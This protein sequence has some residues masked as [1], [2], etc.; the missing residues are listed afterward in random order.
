MSTSDAT[1]RG[2]LLTD[3][4]SG[5]RFDPY[6]VQEEALLAWFTGKHGVLVCA[7]TGMGKTVI[8][9]AAMFEALKSGGRA[10]YTTPLVALT[11]QKFVEM[12]QRAVEWGFS[13]SD[14]GLVTGNRRI[15]PQARI[16]VVVAEILL[17]RLLDHEHFQFDD[18][19]SVVMDE[20]H[21]FAD[22]ERGI[23]WEMSLGLLPK[24]IRTLL[25][26]AT[27]GNAEEFR[28]WL[29]RSHN[30]KLQL[31]QSSTRRVPLTFQWVGD[32]ML[33][34]LVVDMAMGD[35]MS[36]FTPALVFC[37]NREECWSIAENLKGK[38]LIDEGRQSLLAYELKKHDW[39]EGVGPK[40]KQI[41]QRG[42]GV[43]HAGVLGKYRRIVEHLF[44]EK[45]LS[46]TVCTETLAAGI[47]L[48]ARSVILPTILKGPFDNKKLIDPS[49]AHQMFGRAGRPQFDTRGY[50]YALAHD[51]DVKI[52]RWAERYEQFPDNPK[53]A[54]L[55]R[56]KKELKK[57][58][59]KRR[60][61]ITYWTEDQFNKLIASPP[62]SLYSKGRLP[63]R[64]LAHTLSAS[65]DV[66]LLR[67]LISKRFMDTGR[68][69]AAQKQLDHMLLTLWRAGFVKLDPKPPANVDAPPTAEQKPAEKKP[70]PS[71]LAQALREAGAA[72]EA[73][74]SRKKSP[75]EAKPTYLATHAFA[76]DRLPL[77]TAFRSINPLF[78][79]FLIN[80]L[81]AA[82]EAEI[83]QAIE[84]VLDLPRPVARLLQVPPVDE[85]PPGPLGHRID[86]QLLKLGL[87]DEAQLTGNVDENDDSRF[88]DEPPRRLTLADKLKLLF[89]H[90]Y[91]NVADLRIQPVWAAG[92]LF[93]FGGDFNKF[94]LSRRLQKQEGIVF[95]HLLRLVLLLGEFGEICPAELDV[96]QWSTMIGSIRQRIVESCQRV[97]PKSTQ[98]T[99]ELA[100]QK[101]DK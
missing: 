10:Y 55:R 74:K 8:A 73:D 86:P 2:E 78:G 100:E 81:G 33:D 79:V 19:T 17:N 30:R 44:Q 12:Q 27:V 59:P 50:V 31:V 99:L 67:E 61:N 18:V 94:V 65:P 60:T 28:Y 26:S 64:V 36:R 92:E 53:D 69:A 34:E 5:L 22:P 66:Q 35:E 70:P 98:R 89:D 62:G 6:P 1:D 93:V 84:S 96:D 57:K 29:E 24:H 46:V 39:S 101:G 43:H 21:S 87:A 45:L 91:P 16:L 56:R 52:A 75:F 82:N 68:I 11:D 83:I 20:F 13:E 38:K 7:P 32:K 97:D 88:H 15:N 42:V 40:L 9:E 58:K 49:G 25:L 54:T 80:H 14:V 85:L 37:F 23:V 72:G 90:E 71:L 51:D 95:R 3:Y 48:P 4:L 63:W 47:N 76:T 77:L 41:L